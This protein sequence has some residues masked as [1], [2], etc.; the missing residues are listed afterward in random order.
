[1][2]AEEISASEYASIGPG[3]GL[4]RLMAIAVGVTLNVIVA[5]VTM[6]ALAVKHGDVAC[7]Q[8]V[9]CQRVPPGVIAV[10]DGMLTE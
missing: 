3:G 6:I 7:G 9:P 5:P 2:L 10:F 8:N 1:M 4:I